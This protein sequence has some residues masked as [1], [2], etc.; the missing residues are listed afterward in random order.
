MRITEDMLV[1]ALQMQ[2]VGNVQANLAGIET[3]AAAAAAFG[4]K[5]LVTPEMGVTGYANWDDIPHLAETRS[6]P[7]IQRLTAIAAAHDITIVAGFPEIEGETIYN[8]AA[9][10]GPAAEATFYR[11]CHLLAH[12]KKPSFHRRP[13]SRRSCRSAI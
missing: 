12:S 13:S 11:K 9:M 7:I 4:A 5:L 2:P 6:G 3:A 10:I 1:A 8:T